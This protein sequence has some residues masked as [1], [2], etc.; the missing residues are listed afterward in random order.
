MSAG[1][2]IE[3]CLWWEYDVISGDKVLFNYWGSEKSYIEGS[4]YHFPIEFLQQTNT[5]AV[6]HFLL[7]HWEPNQEHCCFAELNIHLYDLKKNFFF[8]SHVIL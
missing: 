7:D 1:L 3:Y 5:A 6:I 2:H 4:Q 8:S